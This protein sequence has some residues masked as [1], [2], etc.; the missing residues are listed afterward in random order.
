MNLVG[1]T[2]IDYPKALGLTINTATPVIKFTV[3][4]PR[5]VD[6][7]DPSTED[8]IAILLSIKID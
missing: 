3:T 7:S 1:T 8:K 6:D 4:V 2:L 5:P